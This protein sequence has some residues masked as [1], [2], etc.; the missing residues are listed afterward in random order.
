MDM[1]AYKQE[2]KTRVRER[3]L[4]SQI[5][6]STFP[7]CRKAISQTACGVVVDGVCVYDTTCLIVV[8][9]RTL[10]LAAEKCQSS[11]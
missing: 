4:D 9:V 8:L 11:K 3:T 6:L 1:Y 5:L 10:S 2:N 7:R